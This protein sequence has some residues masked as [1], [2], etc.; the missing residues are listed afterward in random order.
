MEMMK[1]M[2]DLILY[3]G[4]SARI[5]LKL[6]EFIEIFIVENDDDFGRA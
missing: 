5:G 1:R 3:F 4:K 6:Q 2:A